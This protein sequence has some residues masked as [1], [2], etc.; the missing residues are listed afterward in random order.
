VIYKKTKKKLKK[1]KKALRAYDYDVKRG[2]VTFAVEDFDQVI[3]K[4]M[5]LCELIQEGELN[6]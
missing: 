4:Y 3:E 2:T 6:K 5:D 1:L